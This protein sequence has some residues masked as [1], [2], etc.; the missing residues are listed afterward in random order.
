MGEIMNLIDEL[1]A[2]IESLDKQIEE[3]KKIIAVSKCCYNCAESRIF[4]NGDSFK[5]ICNFEKECKAGE[6]WKPRME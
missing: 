6:K 3:L 1:N 5:I 4:S 2:K